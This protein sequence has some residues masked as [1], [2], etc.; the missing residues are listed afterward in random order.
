MTWR[1][2]SAIFVG[3]NGVRAAMNREKI[4]TRLQQ[5]E[6][7]LRARGVAHAVLFGSRARGDER[8]ESDYDILIAIDPSAPVGGAASRWSATRRS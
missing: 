2:L 4:I 8:P 7:T 3:E 6:A 5:H 1:W